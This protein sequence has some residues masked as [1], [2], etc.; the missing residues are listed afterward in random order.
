M[1][2]VDANFLVLMFDH[3]AMPHIPRGADRIRH[4]I[5]ILTS[6]RQTIVIPTPAISE[7]VVGRLPRLNEIITEIR[8]Q[9]CFKIQDFDQ[10][11]AIETGII[12]DAT[13]RRRSETPP[14][15]SRNAFKYDAMIAATARVLG[16]DA[17]CTDDRGYGKW[18]DGTNIAVRKIADLP[19]PPQPAQQP[20]PFEAGVTASPSP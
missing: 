18:V 12:I 16:A 20:L 7:L 10:P 1:I 3:D 6:D 15:D 2:V 14:V 8:R 19:L 13:F 5:D 4:Y 11:I 9:R 17:I